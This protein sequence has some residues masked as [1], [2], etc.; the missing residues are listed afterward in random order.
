MCTVYCSNKYHFI[1]FF[2]SCRLLFFIE[3]AY[4]TLEKIS[5]SELQFAS[6]KWAEL[7]PTVYLLV[8]LRLSA[9]QLSWVVIL[10]Q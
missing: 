3:H 10:V 6:L 1:S 8:G 9:N 5:D 2:K 4:I 7:G